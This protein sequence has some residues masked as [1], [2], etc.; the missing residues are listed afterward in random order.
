[1]FTDTSYKTV[2]R[3]SLRSEAMVG[4][5]PIMYCTVHVMWKPKPL[6]LWYIKEKRK[7]KCDLEARKRKCDDPFAVAL[8]VSALE[9]FN[10][11][12]R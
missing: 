8:H 7:N 4:E 11:E 2:K 9:D 1:M 6:R 10:E 5:E 12:V 3:Q